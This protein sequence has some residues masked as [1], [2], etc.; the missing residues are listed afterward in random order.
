MHFR[1]EFT[2]ASLKLGGAGNLRLQRGNF[3]GEFTAASL[4]RSQREV[5][6]AGLPHFRGEFTAASLKRSSTASNLTHGL[7][8]AA[9][10]LWPH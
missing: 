7:I 8:S 6:R 3:R 4:K 1:G 10:W 2:A 5:I 9:T